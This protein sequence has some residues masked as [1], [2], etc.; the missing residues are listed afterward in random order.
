MRVRGIYSYVYV[1]QHSESSL[2]GIVSSRAHVASH[3]A[4]GCTVRR[5]D[6][7]QRRVET[8]DDTVTAIPIFL[9]SVI[10]YQQHNKSF[11]PEELGK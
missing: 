8:G 2:E 10:S 4:A 9:G 3:V 7:R 6:E 5:R 1:E 11:D